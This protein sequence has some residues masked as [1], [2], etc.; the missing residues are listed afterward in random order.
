MWLYLKIL[1]LLWVINFV[2]PL[3]TYLFEDKWS[4]PLDR[5]YHFPDGKPLLGA[6]KTFRG[7]FGAVAAG[8]VGGLI[9]G[10]P[11]WLGLGAGLL[12]MAGD[13]ASSFIKRRLR[14]SSGEI[15]PVLDQ[16]F[17]GLFPFFMI[18]PSLSLGAGEILLLLVL[19]SFG[20]Y[21]G[22]LFLNRVL[23]AIPFENYPRLLR[24]R[25][26]LKEFRAC[27]IT[28]TPLR[29]FINFEDAF[30]YHVF[31]KTVMRLMGV[32]E[33]GKRNALQLKMT[34]VAFS[35]WNLPASFENYTIL[36]LSDL[37]LDGLEGLT[38]KVKAL[39]RRHP[40]D[41]CIFGGDLRMDHYGPLAEALARFQSLLPEIQARDGIIGVMGN[42][43]CLEMIEPLEESGMSVLVNDSRPIE[44]NGE[45]IW[46]VGVDDPHYFK[47]HDLEQ[48]F[49]EVPE[50]SFSILVAHSNEIYR[51]ASAYHPELYLCGHTHG[52][53]IQVPVFG[54]IFTHSKAPR[55]LLY[56]PWKYD[57]MLGYTTC[58]VGVSGVPVR[59]STQG[60][61][62]W[63]TLKRDRDR[64]LSPR[65]DQGPVVS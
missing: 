50:E 60:E 20:A 52:G 42:H 4:A 59:F 33:K 65:D 38:E 22:S 53:Q 64:G 25:V 34:E 19:F 45:R 16:G 8:T 2:P 48:A 21:F 58:G 54:A 30:Y 10:F 56:G 41:L 36:F 1:T 43:D 44:R 18:R 5:G 37:H 51:Q 61:V 15:V 24:P 6:H 40:V 11:W 9:F 55:S 28:S 62:V 63:I 31:M 49:A 32:Y 46:I 12:S 47:C 35:F 57:G 3:L 14:I 29:Y 39:V 26:R 7:L 17:E 13:L 27:Q 23:L